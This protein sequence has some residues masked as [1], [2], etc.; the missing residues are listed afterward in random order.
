MAVILWTIQD[1][2]FLYQTDLDRESLLYAL[3]DSES[4]LA[5]LAAKLKS[6]IDALEET[7]LK[8][9]V[10][11]EEN[12]VLFDEVQRLGDKQRLSSLVVSA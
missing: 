3:K 6:A 12:R 10:S 2:L 4:M 7:E 1:I 9:S 8:L 5:Q 11:L